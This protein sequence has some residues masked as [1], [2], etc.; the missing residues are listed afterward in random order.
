MY[1]RFSS[2]VDGTRRLPGC[3]N[4]PGQTK[5]VFD[6]WQEVIHNVPL[7]TREGKVDGPSHFGAVG[8]TD[9]TAPANGAALALRGMALPTSTF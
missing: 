2:L 3:R 4:F 8:D 1:F 5:T 9:S 6:G 7:I